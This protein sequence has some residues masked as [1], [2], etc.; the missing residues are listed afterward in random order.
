MNHNNGD[1]FLNN[2]ID[3]ITWMAPR[4]LLN[5]AYTENN[6]QNVISTIVVQND[7]G[8][9]QC[10][11]CEYNTKDKSNLTRHIKSIHEGKLHH[12]LNVIT[13]QQVILILQDI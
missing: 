9:H 2:D 1:S 5:G 4:E 11:Q 8:S 3:I 13:R 6:K 12:A 10:S 7:G